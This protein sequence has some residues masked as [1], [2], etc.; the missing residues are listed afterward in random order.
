MSSLACV[1]PGQGSQSVGMLTDVAEHYPAIRRTFEEAS[2]ALQ[3]DLWELCLQGPKEKLNQT[4]YTQPALL[5]AS[6]ALYRQSRVSGAEEPKVVA[7]HSLG[8]YSAL[9]VA[10]CLGFATATKLVAR[11]G[12]LMQS[13][14]GDREGLMAAVLGLDD[15]QVE[16][17]CSTVR[18]QNS[19]AGWVSPA[20][21]NS[22]GQVVIAGDKQAVSLAI[23]G[24]KE[25]GARRAMELAVSVPSHCALM[26]PASEALAEEIESVSWSDAQIPIVQNV[27][28]QAR[29]SSVAIKSR[30]LA[31][32]YKPVRW[33]QSVEAMS[34]MDISKF[35]ECGPGAVLSGL[36]KR[37]IKGIETDRSEDL[38]LAL[39]KGADK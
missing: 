25:S 7:G 26:K 23:E 28:A 9:V 16:K 35:R 3:Y 11:R 24:C 32:L 19:R 6:V 8:E 13:A 4:A 17:V 12:E 29:T 2:E 21:Y 33:H 38:L 20:N 31:Q 36:I 27:D 15:E 14:L 34:T 39:G 5:V 10:G 22:P 18:E 37:C 30:L 1:F